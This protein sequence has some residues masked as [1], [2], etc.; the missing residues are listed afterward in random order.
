MT[1]KQLTSLNED[2]AI[3]PEL[4]Q[5]LILKRCAKVLAPVL[6]MLILAILKFREWPTLWGEQWVIYLL[7]GKCRDL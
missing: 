6:H 4:V 7:N 2:N 1:K 5:T 3:G